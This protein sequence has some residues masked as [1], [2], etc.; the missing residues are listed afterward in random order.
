MKLFCISILSLFSVAGFS[1]S[2]FPF[3]NRVNNFLLENVEQGRIDYKE[4]I[5]DTSTLDALI[6]EIAQYNLDNRS[7]DHKL[8]FYINAYNVLVIKQVTNHYPIDSPLEVKGFF[9][10][11]WH[12]VAGERMTLDQLEFDKIFRNFKD[13]RIHFALGCAAKSCPFLYANAYTPEHVQEQLTFRAELI[14]DRED[15]VRVNDKEKIVWVSKVFDWYRDLFVANAG[16]IIKFI[17]TYR[18]YKVSEDFEVRFM[19]YD[20]SLNEPE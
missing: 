8:A 17:N 10:R 13:G 9:D 12:T 20:W 18:H 4:L 6:S 15:Y 5:K 1:Q 3:F 2:Q 16:S 19:K 14:I 7:E 11:Y